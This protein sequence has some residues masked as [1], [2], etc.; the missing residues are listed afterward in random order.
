MNDTQVQD[1]SAP[2]V[3]LPL[4]G[5]RVLVTGAGSGIGEATAR[6]AAEQGAAVAAADIDHAAVS[7]VAEDIRS[8][9]GSAIALAADVSQEDQVR[10]LFTDAATELGPIT[11]VVNNAGVIVTKPLVET[12]QEEWDRCLDVNAR[13][14]FFG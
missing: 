4:Q 10:R 7:R 13:G 12:T 1:G 3:T 11:G 6:M 14:V 8:R 2:S 9:G 5:Q